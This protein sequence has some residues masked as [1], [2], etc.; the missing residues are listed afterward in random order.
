VADLHRRAEVSQAANGRYLEAMSGVAETTTVEKLVTPWCGR[1]AE[2]GAGG[3]MVRALNPLAAEDAALLRAISDPKWE[4]NGLRNH[5]LAETLYGE[6]PADPTERKRRSARVSRLL[7]LLRA[8]GIL[9]KVPTTNR[10]LVCV[11]AR[12]TIL[13]VLAAR[14]ANPDELT[15][16]AAA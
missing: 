13:A 14:N 11:K 6:A 8:H 9:K 12:A 7:R 10:Y 1:V 2:P 4:V 15:K 5:D 16:R 3:R